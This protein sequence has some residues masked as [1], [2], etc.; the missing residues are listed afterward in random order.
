MEMDFSRIDGLAICGYE[1]ASG[2][3]NKMPKLL[4]Q[5]DVDS[6]NAGIMN[7]NVRNKGNSKSLLEGMKYTHH[8][9]GGMADK[10]LAIV[11]A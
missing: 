7:F 5:L 3:V 8:D 10:E 4:D 1:Y 2:A 9:C 11:G 6:F